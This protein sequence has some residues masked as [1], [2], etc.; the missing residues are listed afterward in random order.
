MPRYTYR[1]KSSPTLTREGQVYASGPQ[2]AVRQL[3]KQG[4]FPLSLD[5]L[6]SPSEDLGP[7]QWRR[8][9]FKETVIFTRQLSSLIGSGV[10]IINSLNIL[11][12]Q[13]RS[14]YLKTIIKE[15]I[16]KIK[17][18][19]SLSDSLGVYP[20]VFSPLFVSMV[21]TGEA[22]GTLEVALSRLATFLEKEDEF[23]H[24]LRQALAYP[25]LVFIVGLLTVVTLLWFVIP[26]LTTM[27][28]DTG[29]VL[30]LP[31]RWLIATSNLLRRYGWLMLLAVAAGALL[32]ERIKRT[33]PGR[34]F[35]DAF[36]FKIPFI[37]TI[38]RKSE[39]SRLMR[40]LSLL[41]S[42][43]MPILQSLETASSVLENEILRRDSQRCKEG[44]AS[45]ESL[46]ACVAS[47][48]F[49]PAFAANIIKVGEE[50]G[51]LEGSLLRIAEEYDKEVDR[52][53]KNF[54]QLL[55]PAM[56]LLIGLLVGFI[57]FSML[58]PI[59]QLNLFVR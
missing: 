25:L 14:R 5:V 39:I 49:F 52:A 26:R 31:T 48:R 10:N 7:R 28:L 46:S 59:F 17:D 34:L 6:E 13:T 20:S 32:F 58:L 41:L 19:R 38:I 18:G 54:T 1:A 29:Q 56:I 3:A 53:L 21:Y 51:T 4:L 30:P 43:G 33:Q 40:M 55:E 35:W 12:R 42:S 8:V 24:S 22:A 36:K 16:A 27:F 47:S 2:D 45:G 57:V 50:S 44:I 9:S 23:K 15:V 11:L 37:G